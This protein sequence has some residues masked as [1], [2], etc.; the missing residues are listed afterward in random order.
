M[1]H[2]KILFIC[3][4]SEGNF[5][6]VAFLLPQGKAKFAMIRNGRTIWRG[7]MSLKARRTKEFFKSLADGFSRAIS[8]RKA[9]A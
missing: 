7:N 3:R 4:S 6:R 8:R 9:T 2:Q 5:Y 1:F